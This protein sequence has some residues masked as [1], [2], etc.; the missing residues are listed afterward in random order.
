[1]SDVK[2][3][4]LGQPVEWLKACAENEGGRAVLALQGYGSIETAGYFARE[5]ARY[6][7]A[8]LDGGGAEPLFYYRW[9]RGA[10]LRQGAIVRWTGPG[11]RD[12]VTLVG[13]RMVGRKAV[14]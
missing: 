2:R 11:A 3:W 13:P 7:I 1:M 5:A 6:A 8:L 9:E 12:F 10:S 14:R 4:L